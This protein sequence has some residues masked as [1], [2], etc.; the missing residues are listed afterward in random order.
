[1]NV[2]VELG[3]EA[4]ALRFTEPQVGIEAVQKVKIVGTALAT[5]TFGALSSDVEG[6]T[7]QVLT[8]D[9]GGTKVVE[10]EARLK[11]PKAGAT[12]G[13][14][15]VPTTLPS[16]PSLSLPVY[17]QVKGTVT[18]EPPLV[19]FDEA[20]PDKVQPVVLRA[21]RP[22]LK[23]TGVFD[24]SGVVMGKALAQKDGTW[25]VELSLTDHAKAS[26]DP[27]STTVRLS[28]AYPEEA[29]IELVA[30]RGTSVKRTPGTAPLRRPLAGRP[31]LPPTAKPAPAAPVHP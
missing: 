24:P 19:T 15:R 30:S 26:K 31:P 17:A 27:F 29:V 25:R 11:A 20:A 5:T 13:A 3:F 23:I 6:L 9:E 22:G 18:A 21:S 28:T 7:A 8:R 12:H 1:M 10:L 14:I 4:P 16:M 2:I